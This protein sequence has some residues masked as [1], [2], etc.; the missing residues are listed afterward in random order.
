MK[1]KEANSPLFVPQGFIPTQEQ[2]NIQLSQHHISLIQANAGAAKTTTLALRIGE[3]IARGL[4]PDK[5]LA[6]VFTDEAR[7]VMKSRMVAIGIPSTTA[8]LV[9]VYTVDAFA[10][11]CLEQIEG[12]T[13]PVEPSAKALKPYVLSALE[14]VSERYLHRVEFL[15]I[16]THSIAMSQFLECQVRLKARL[17][18]LDDLEEIDNVGL[19]EMA[20]RLGVPLA[21]Y[22]TCLEYERIRA[23]NFEEVLFRGPF[24]CTYDLAR[25]LALDPQTRLQLPTYKLIVGDEL[26]DLNEAS[27]QIMR[28][29]LERGD[30]YFVGAGDEDQ[31]IYST[32]GADKKYLQQGFNQLP[33]KALKLPLTM[34]YRH[35]PHLAYAMRALKRKPVESN[36]PLHTQ[37]I[38]LHYASADPDSCAELVVKSLQSWSKQKLPMEACAIL[39]RERH[40]SITIENALMQANIGYRTEKMPGYL[41]REEILFLRGMLAIAL[42]NLEAVKSIDV[43]RSIV[44]ALAIFG[45][46]ELTPKEMEYAKSVIAQDPHIL[47]AFFTGKLQEAGS[48]SGPSSIAT[49]VA[50]IETI[51]PNTAAATVLT[52]IVSRMDLKSVTRRI[53]V[54][55]AQASIV[56]RSIDGFIAMAEKLAMNLLD[57]SVWLGAAD[58]FAGSGKKK[59]LVLLDCV[60]N[61]KGKEFE[62]VIMPFLEIAEFPAAN[63]KRSEEENLFYVGATRAIQ[64]LSLLSPLALE[65]RSPFLAGMDLPTSKAAA[66]IA[67]KENS[68]QEVAKP[69]RVDL[70]VPFAD[71]DLAKAIGAKWDLARKVWYVGGDANPAS[72]EKWLPRGGA[73]A[74]G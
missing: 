49:V 16:Q 7:E 55:A 36:L 9:H 26:H 25:K 63:K 67:L 17:E 71:K 3:A 18:Q 37:I 14:R 39:V 33:H 10:K 40:Q 47:N 42:K 59:N 24:D 58:E 73:R 30:T 66:D 53:Y 1:P 2:R 15:D 13:L 54:H 74:G 57:F 46:V 8:R 50:Y 51:D 65:L 19:G 60:A 35:G 61:A 5:I 28:A 45:E 56:S 22:L 69:T 72:Y 62:H 68:R 27:F 52:E 70:V 34:T 31:V 38:E 41:R 11:K 23:G 12:F 29:L 44:E 32:Y 20:E 64:R 21:D 43:R 6:L 4:A 48:Q